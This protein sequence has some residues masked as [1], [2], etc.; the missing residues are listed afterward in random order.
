MTVFDPIQLGIIVLLPGQTVAMH[1]DVPWYWGAT[2]FN[3]PQWLLIAMESSGL[4]ENIRVRQSQGVAYLHKWLNHEKDGGGFYFYPKGTGG[5]A[6]IVPAEFN[7]GLVLDGSVLIHGVN[8]YQPKKLPPII[9][10]SDK[11]SLVYAGDDFWQLKANDE[12]IALYKTSDLRISLVWRSRCFE[13]Q[14]MKQ[15]WA[16]YKDKIDVQ[17]VLKVL[18]DDMKLKG[19]SNVDYLPPLDLALKIL[20][21]YVVYPVEKCSIFP[22]NYCMLSKIVPTSVSG[23]INSLLT[24]IC[25]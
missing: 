13:S 7:T 19:I 18:K 15:K 6:E 21:T 2:R 20:D 9:N 11:N 3:I 8:T 25:A 16:D 23:F 10:P 12:V 17:D 5:R 24:P 4:F 1:Y 14:E 22:W